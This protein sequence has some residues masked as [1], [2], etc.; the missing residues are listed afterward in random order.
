MALVGFLHI[1]MRFIKNL[2]KFSAF[3]PYCLTTKTS[4]YGYQ[5]YDLI[6]MSFD[7]GNYLRI[8]L[9]YLNCYFF[10]SFIENDS[11]QQ[12]YKLTGK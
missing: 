5:Y 12:T 4:M 1:L 7:G 9:Q 11:T 3:D 8:L 10:A 2:K 6:T